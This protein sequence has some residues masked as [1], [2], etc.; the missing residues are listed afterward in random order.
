MCQANT[1]EKIFQGENIVHCQMLLR[2]K[3]RR[4]P[5]MDHRF[6]DSLDLGASFWK[7]NFF[8]IDSVSFRLLFNRSVL[9]QNAA[10]ERN[11]IYLLG[12][13]HCIEP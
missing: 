9:S 1:H 11:F 2:S 10:Q 8:L 6:M 5:R 12:G 7:I 3:I 13:R 4:G